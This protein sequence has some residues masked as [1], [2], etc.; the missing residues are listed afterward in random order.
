[1]FGYLQFSICSLYFGPTKSDTLKSFSVAINQDYPQ[2]KH[3]PQNNPR[4][5]YTSKLNGGDMLFSAAT[6]S[7]KCWLWYYLRVQPTGS[8]YWMFVHKLKGRKMLFIGAVTRSFFQ[9][10]IVVFPTGAQQVQPDGYLERPYSCENCCSY[11]SY[12]RKLH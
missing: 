6:R 9:V 11:L 3:L 1:M 4:K 8:T 5:I 10:L 7:G 2:W 12:L